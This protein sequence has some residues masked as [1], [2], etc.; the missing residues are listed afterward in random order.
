MTRLVDKVSAL[1]DNLNGVTN[2]INNIPRSVDINV[3][4]HYIAPSIPDGGGGDVDWGGAQAAGGDY[5]VR[6]PTL[7]LAGEAG[8]ERASFSGGGRTGRSD[9]PSL[10]DVHTAVKETNRL[11]RDQPRAIAVAVS[12]AVALNRR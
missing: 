3:Q 11:L 5:F 2:S 9:G 12:D 8:P 1:I 7:F 4:G 10:A 6:R